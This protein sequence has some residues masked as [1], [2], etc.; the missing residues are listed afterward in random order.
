MS[1]VLLNQV[2]SA[3]LLLQLYEEALASPE[4][5]VVA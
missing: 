4:R 2:N 5:R 1:F 3:V